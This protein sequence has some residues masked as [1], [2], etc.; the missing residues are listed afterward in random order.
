MLSCVR[1]ASKSSS[2]VAGPLETSLQ[3]VWRNWSRPE[4]FEQ[5][6]YQEKP[7][8]YEYRLT[9]KGLDLYP[10]V[11]TIVHWGDKWHDDGRWSPGAPLPPKLQ[12]PNL[13]PRGVRRVQRRA[14]SEREMWIELR[15]GHRR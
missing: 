9:E 5:Q 13:R 11:M 3:T 8:R 14:S 7:D 12:P 1:V 2:R 15:D 10:V 4:I 6:L